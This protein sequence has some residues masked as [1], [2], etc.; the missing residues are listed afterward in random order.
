M[1]LLTR[2]V[3]PNNLRPLFSTLSFAKDVT[4]A[5]REDASFL[6]LARRAVFP[7]AGDRDPALERNPFPPLQP[8]EVG[9]LRDRRIA[10]VGSG[11]SGATSAIIG[12]QRA[13]EE[14]GIEP[15]AIS[16]SSGSVLFGA[17]WACGF[18]AET[19]ARFWLTLRLRD[20]L[21]A[22]WFALLKS[23]KRGLAGWA[24]LIRGDRLEASLRKLVGERT[25]SETKYPFAMVVWN[26]DLNR[27]EVIGTRATP[28]LPVA[29]AMRIG[30]SIPIF[31]EPVRLNGH[32]YGDG[33][34]VDIFP[35][36][37]VDPERPDL[38]LG[39]NS[40][41]PSGFTGDDLTG[42]HDQ[43]LAILRASAQLRWSGMIALAR[44]QVAA[45]GDRLELLEPVPYAEVRGAKFYE[46][47][48]D[49]SSWPRFMRAGRDAARAALIRRASDAGSRSPGAT[50][51]V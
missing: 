28:N 37:T 3:E 39:L 44:E 46:T 13:F 18:D 33:G 50:F 45:E 10:V 40:Y 15:V 21:D 25:L 7:M 24:G 47:F 14:A 1:G 49:R 32:V 31:V 51:G 41:L 5:L 36:R 16:G 11:G 43:T 35:L 22:D 2:V 23:L 38:I 27:V 30:I 9:A 20:Y 34:I 26:V 8:L 19:I 12:V 42:W 48:V 29:R 4:A 6:A 17:L